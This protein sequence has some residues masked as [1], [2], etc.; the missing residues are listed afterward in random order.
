MAGK[1]S[2]NRVAGALAAGAL[3]LTVAACDQSAGGT[4]SG[5]G[6]GTGSGGGGEGPVRVGLVT[7]T[8]GLV[9][10]YGKQF[11]E[12]FEIGMDYATDGTDEAAGRPIEVTTEDDA[13]DPAQATSIATDLIGQG[14]QI[15]TGSVSSGVAL[16]LAPLAEQNDILYISGAAAADQITGINDN[17]FRSGRQTYQ[18]VLTAES[19][20]EDIEGKKVVVFAQDYDFGQANVAAVS[21]VLGEAGGAEVVPVLAPLEASDFTPFVRRVVDQ[22]PDLLFVAWAGDTT[23]AMWQSLAQQGVFDRTTV[24]TGLAERASF[25]S[26]GPAATQID[27]L[28]HYFA[29]A[30]ENEPN[31][32]L[33]EELQKQGKTADI[34]HADGF[35]AAQMVVRAIEEGGGDVAGMIQALEG[36]SFTAPKGEQ[37]VRAED[38]AMLQP[39]F[40]ARLVDSGGELTPELVETL[41]PEQVA[42]P[43]STE[44]STQ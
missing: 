38:H 25:E 17:T 7:S 43:V 23:N 15:I 4:S 3:A 30:S 22:Q 6:G 44:S 11:V 12:G 27:F 32:F 20:V 10:A 37:T 42:P 31:T 21:A 29:E 35:V 24:V 16:Q 8:S 5:G 19:F 13:S 33:L 9:S 26:Y 40:Q 41:P 36:W 28:A 1:R 39:M 2:I 34:F 18:D 14:Y